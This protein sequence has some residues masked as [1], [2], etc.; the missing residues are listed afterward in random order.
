M[1]RA[2]VIL[3]VW[4]GVL[5]L[6]GT[7]LLQSHWEAAVVQFAALALVPTALKLLDIR[8]VA[9]H[10]VI[11]AAFCGAY[12]FYPHPLA[13]ILTIPYLVWATWTVIRETTELLFVKKANLQSWVKVAALAYW[14]TGALWALAFI[15]GYSILTFDPVIT[16]LT[17]AH[18][19]VAGFAL[20]VIIYCLLSHEPSRFNRILAF[21]ALAG[22]PTVALGIT[23]T[24]LGITHV[25]EWSSAMLFAAMALGVAWQQW[26]LA[27]KSG[28]D[29]Y[30]TR[31]WKTSAACL[32]FG[33][34][35]A[36]LYSL[37]FALPIDWV[38][39]PNMKIWHGTM[40]AVGFAWL[41]LNGWLANSRSL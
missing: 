12:V 30:A 22:M 27:G 31:L 34:V 3:P 25:V 6:D 41:A 33:G 37:R 40:N 28:Y 13:P 2:L 29:H 5:L 20:T 21:S 4:C 32:V 1:R 16:G 17:A 26:K 35:L 10:Y 19:H 24:K 14:A 11:I 18:F 36:G 39:I 38:N 23:L 9:L 8:V 15:S 7:D